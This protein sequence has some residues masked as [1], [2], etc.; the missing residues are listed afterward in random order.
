MNKWTVWTAALAMASACSS[1]SGSVHSESGT[2][3]SSGASGSG[4]TVLASGGDASGGVNASSGGRASGG[5]T[6]QTASGGHA[7]SGGANSDGR[8]SERDASA[9]AN[10]AIRDAAILDA[11]AVA[12]VEVSPPKPDPCPDAPDVVLLDPGN[13]C[14]P[15]A[16]APGTEVGTMQLAV[17]DTNVYAVGCA[18]GEC[19]EG[20]CSETPGLIYRVPRC[21]GAVTEIQSLRGVEWGPRQLSAG[22]PF[23]GGGSYLYAQGTFDSGTVLRIPKAGGPATVLDVGVYCT[24]GAADATGYYCPTRATIEKA[25]VGSTSVTS[26]FNLGM[27]F[28]FDAATLPWLVW[29]IAVHGDA[30]FF[31]NTVSVWSAPVGGSRATLLF[32]TPPSSSIIEAEMADS[33]AIYVSDVESDSV[34]RVHRIPFDGS[35]RST[36]PSPSTDASLVGTDSGYLYLH[37]GAAQIVREPLRGKVTAE[38]ITNSVTN[39]AGNPDRYITAVAVRDGWLYFAESGKLFAARIHGGIIPDP[40]ADAG[41]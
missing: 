15:D 25:A 26:V 7:N 31:S 33:D 37:L 9:D 2:S 8:G 38:T 41:H 5:G 4:G 12:D 29:Q 16:A 23:I 39:S 35:P 13:G 18:K 40:L 36:Y 24:F 28:D 17:D 11:Y 32:N 21:G 30:L 27:A 1:C 22:P 14:R 20:F 34:M 6:S 3:A 19:P 10:A